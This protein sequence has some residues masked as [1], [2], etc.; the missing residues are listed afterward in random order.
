MQCLPD[1]LDIEESNDESDEEEDDDQEGYSDLEGSAQPERGDTS[2]TAEEC[3]GKECEAPLQPAAKP[4]IG[5]PQ[6]ATKPSM[7]NWPRLCRPRT[8]LIC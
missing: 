2:R 5:G 8:G 3:P 7:E 6:E 4:G 1:L